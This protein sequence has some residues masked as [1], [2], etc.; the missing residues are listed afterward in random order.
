MTTEYKLSYTAS[1]IDRKLGEIEDIKQELG[2][3]SSG[4]A[5]CLLTIETITIGESGESGTVAVTGITL[6]YST[7]SLNEG[8]NMMLAASVSPSDA[9]N[10]TV[11]W[12]SSN[13]D[14]A[15]VDNGL[16]TAV[17]SGN[18]TI[19][20]KSAENN[21]IK[22]TCSVA[23][24]AESGGDE[25]GEDADG[26]IM[27]LSLPPITKGAVLNKDGKTEYSN[28]A[29]HGYYKLPYTDGMVVS[30]V[31]A[32]MWKNNYPPI[33]V[34]DGGAVTV[35]TSEE[36]SVSGSVNNYVATLT[37]F[38]E[39]AEVFVNVSYYDFENVPS[40][41][42]YVPGGAESGG[43]EP[44]GGG[45]GTVKVQLSSHEYTGGIL[46]K[47]GK[48]VFDTDGIHFEIPY[49]EGMYISTGT[50][51]A[52]V[53]NYPPFIVDDNGVVTVPEFSEGGHTCV[54]G[55]GTNYITTL[56]GF[57]ENAKVY[58]NVLVHVGNSTVQEIL[59]P[60]D[61]YYYTYEK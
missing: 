28:P 32:G 38:A 39:S 44:G 2:N 19:T 11:L 47:D 20:A 14:V 34:I 31:L 56:T 35:A 40:L 30:T 37:G 33:M 15:R 50:N 5:N 61:V 54:N 16:V 43:A 48:T 22:A 3:L 55:Y 52:W 53:A 21:S 9:T 18:C 45:S 23:V 7:I 6:D 29:A 4:N 59:N 13:T 46:K 51:A 25:P 17:A 60:V 26:K 1:E 42:Y 8:E 12:E 36:T 57:S 24:A 49:F 41:C 10:N 27:L 58:V